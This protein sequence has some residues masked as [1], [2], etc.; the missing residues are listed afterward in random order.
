MDKVRAPLLEMWE[1]AKGVRTPRRLAMVFGGNFLTQ[2][3]Y[4]LCLGACVRAFGIP[5]QGVAAMLVVYIAAAL[6]GGLM[7]VPGGVGVMEAALIA[8][9]EAVGVANAAAV[10]APCTPKP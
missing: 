7:P 1:T 2:V 8:G 10:G 5:A 4:A 3:I 6:F 9:L